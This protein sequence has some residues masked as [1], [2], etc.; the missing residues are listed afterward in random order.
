MAK[1]SMAKRR[2]LCVA[3]MARRVAHRN[4]AAQLG[5]WNSGN[6]GGNAWRKAAKAASAAAALSWQAKQRRVPRLY[7]QRA[8]R[9]KRRKPSARKNSRRASR[10]ARHRA[11][12][13]G[14][15]A[16]HAGAFGVAE[17]RIRHQRQ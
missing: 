7:H 8:A 10:A 6:V 2:R 13:A 15:S 5:G 16:W 3:L 14:I 1:A 12:A 11:W 17:K 9:G 4:V